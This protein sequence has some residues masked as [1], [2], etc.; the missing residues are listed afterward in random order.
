MKTANPLLSATS[1][2]CH[3]LRSPLQTIQGFAELL[4]ESPLDDQQ[5]RFVDHILRES[6]YMLS[7]SN[8]VL[9]AARRNNSQDQPYLHLENL[10]LQNLFQEI[11]DTAGARAT[12]SGISLRATNESNRVV[13][14]RAKLKQILLNLV[15]NAL[16]FT[17]SGGQVLLDAT[18]LDGFVQIS[19]ADTGLGI[20]VQDQSAIFE[21]FQQCCGRS[22]ENHSGFGL[23]LAIVKS[24]VEQHGG[25][26][27]VESQAGEGSTF[28]FSLSAF[29]ESQAE[30]PFIELGR[31]E[32]ARA[33]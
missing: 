19:V 29:T 14:D 28:L 3:D 9:A 27:W 31:G 32:L 26:I 21:P 17:P 1:L 22:R 18:H 12:A 24:L 7:L 33:H 4:L 20:P 8:S 11:V 25:R 6:A 30:N 10:D 15:D 2:L 13:A 16:K 5:A 23:G